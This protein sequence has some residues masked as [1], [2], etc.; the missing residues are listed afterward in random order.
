[1]P[2]G[3]KFTRV[4]TPLVAQGTDDDGIL[5]WLND[6][7]D[8]ATDFAGQFLLNYND[9]TASVD[10]KP[11]TS[12]GLLQV[13]TGAEAALLIGVDVSDPLVPAVR[14]ISQVGVVYT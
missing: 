14:V 11:V 6:R 1:M 4:P 10:G 5:L 13:Y 7:S 8:A 2:P 12:A 9:P 3:T